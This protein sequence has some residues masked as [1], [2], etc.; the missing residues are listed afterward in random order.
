MKEL[1]AILAIAI[2]L[3][4]G[5]ACSES[6]GEKTTSTNSDGSNTTAK[7]D[8]SSAAT[9]EEITLK[10]ADDETVTNFTTADKTHKVSVKFSE[11]GA[12]KVKGVFTAVNAGG[13]K[14]FKILEKEVELG[15]LMNL[16]NFTARTEREFPAGEY[17][18]DVYVNDKLV[19]T[20]NYKVQ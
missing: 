9:I 17:K 7:N 3:L 11:T 18:F 8:T 4:V 2:L 20:Q 5:L 12:G 10:N 13:E 19:K 14:N 6:G 16:A 1:S 15:S